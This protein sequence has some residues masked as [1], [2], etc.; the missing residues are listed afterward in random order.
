MEFEGKI[1]LVTGGAGGQGAAEARLLAAQGATVIVSDRQVAQGEKL[2]ADIGG[3]AT[4]VEHDVTR[5]DDWARAVGVAEAKG[6]LHGLVNNAGV[7]RPGQ[8]SETDPALWQDHVSVNQ[9]GCFLGLKAAVPAME[10]SG[11]GSIVNVA[12][13]AALRGSGQAFA[14]CATKWALR[15]MS[16]AAALE[17]AGRN[18]RVNCVCPGLVDTQMLSQW[19]PEER[20]RRLAAVPMGRCGTAEEIAEVVLFLLSDRSSYMTG[21]EVAIDGGLAA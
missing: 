20:T 2:A 18:I 19:S 13:T 5:A 12:S 15:G 3:G 17:L 21:A 16:R 11:G 14:Y 1:I 10:R 7:Y 9:F 4:F 8:L 6:G